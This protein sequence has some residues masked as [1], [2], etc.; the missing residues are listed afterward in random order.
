MI[1]QEVEKVFPQWV[2]GD[3]HGYKTLG[4]SGFEA[5][6]VESLRELQSQIETLKAANKNLSRVNDDLLHRVQ[7]LEKEI[8]HTTLP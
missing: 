8:K 1:A 3:E 7:M 5:L 2:G 6:T 4:F